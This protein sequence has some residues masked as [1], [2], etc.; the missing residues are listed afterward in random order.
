MGDGRMTSGTR[1]KFAALVLVIPAFLLQAV[2]AGAGQYDRQFRAFLDQIVM[3]DA[4]AAGVRRAVLDRELKGL[5]P[6]TSLP[7]LTKPGVNDAPV[8]VNYQAEFRSPARYF[9]DSQFNALVGPGR[10]LMKRHASALAG[11]EKRYGVPKR[12]LLAIWARESGYGRAKIPHDAIRVLATR[13]FMGQRQPFFRAELI[14]ALKILQ[15]GDVSRKAL[16]SSWGGALGQPQFLPGSY[17]KYAVD[18]DGDGKRDI[19]NSQVDTLASIANYLSKHGWKTGRD[20]GYEARIPTAISCALEGP[21]NRKP[22]SAWVSG[23]VTRVSGRPFPQHELPQPGN[24][25]MPAGRFGP[26]F[27]ATENFYVIKEYNES[28]VYALFVGHLA[29]RYGANKK[30]VQTWKPIRKTTRGEV[31]KLQLTLESQGHDVGG[32]DGLIGFKTRRSIGK[33]QETAGKRPTCWVE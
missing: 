28:D 10:K 3:P 2:P 4:L 13:A 30:F 23:G 29:D 19:W 5:T 7:G 11:I 6:D 22:I 12:I 21:D 20:W 26:A 1:F 16:R 31:R 8:K 24:I 14:S 15:S 32:A 9:K 33:A 25:L 27:I 17:L 18:F